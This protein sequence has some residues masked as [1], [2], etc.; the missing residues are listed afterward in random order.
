MLRR[1]LILIF[2]IVIISCGFLSPSVDS[3]EQDIQIDS[4]K[5]SSS[6]VET[7]G[8]IADQ[9]LL[10][11]QEDLNL[12][13]PDDII[14]EI[15][16]FGGL[17]G[18]SGCWDGNYNSPA[19]F[20]NADSMQEVSIQKMQYV[21]ITICGLPQNEQVGI[22][23]IYPNRNDVTTFQ[24]AEN[25]SGTNKAEI[26]F[27]FIP[28]I[29]DP[30][31][32]YKFIFSGVGWSLEYEAE[33]INPIGSRLYLFESQLFFV[34][35][36]PNEHIRLLAY[37]AS[38]DNDLYHEFL[39]WQWFQVNEHGSLQ[40]DVDIDG[41][42]YIALGEISGDINYEV[43]GYF[44]NIPLPIHCEGARDPIGIKPLKIAEIIVNN[45]TTYEYDSQSGKLIRAETVDLKGTV[46]RV[47]TNA[48]CFENA[49]VWQVSCPGKQCKYL[50]VPESGPDGYYLRP[51]EEL[52]STS[53]PDPSIISYCP[54]TLPTRLQ[55]GMTA[56]VTRSGMAPQLSLRAQPSMSA[57]KVHVIAAGR[58]MTILQG[59]VCADGSYWWYIRSEQGFEGWAR[60]GDN[61]DYWIDPL[62]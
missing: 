21:D 48:M 41:G 46:V 22:Q 27:S 7:P 40:I 24:D 2:S 16:F 50:F 33:V 36:S 29:D 37:R 54:G 6:S 57:E 52:P 28:R 55:I 39:G 59:P 43:P 20:G 3:D 8:V 32:S 23:L 11:T 58:K 25:T 34:N 51:L 42:E 15:V 14:Q 53:T 13:P 47:E 12:V 30:L 4:T 5:V 19:F 60:E 10:L 38:E 31:G 26:T 1:N 18:S 9:D 35:F 45:L 62:P 17:G 56:E 44:L 49:F 61:E